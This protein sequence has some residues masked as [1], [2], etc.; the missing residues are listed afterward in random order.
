MNLAM[1]AQ[2]ENGP[3]YS[4]H[5]FI[6]AH[7]PVSLSQEKDPKQTKKGLVSV[8]RGWQSSWEERE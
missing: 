1:D 3:I 7:S 5:L 4:F 2:N 6:H 8:I